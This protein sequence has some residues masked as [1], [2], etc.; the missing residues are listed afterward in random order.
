M[1]T[2]PAIKTDRSDKKKMQNKAGDERQPDT[3][4][5]RARLIFSFALSK[6]PRPTRH[7]YRS[8]FERAAEIQFNRWGELQ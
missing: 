6:S 1:K 7:L 4:C 5:P 3:T 2:N 8:R